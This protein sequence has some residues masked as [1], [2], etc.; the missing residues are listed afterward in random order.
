MLKAFRYLKPYWLSVLAIVAL[1]FGQVQA[2]LAL[3]DYMSD[4]VT[5]GIQY[6]GVT[7]S[8][9]AAMRAD[10]LAHM[11]FFSDDAADDYTIV[12]QGDASWEQEYPVVKDQDI[13]VKKDGAT[14]SDESK[15]AFLLVNM[16]DN[17]EVLKHMNLSSS[18]ELYTAMN[19]DPAIKKQI[20]SM[21]DEKLSGFTE[22]NIESAA[23]MAVKSEYTALCMDMEHLQSSYIMKEGGRMLL[24]AA[25]G[26]LA[27]MIAAY[28]ASRTATGAC[29]DMRRDVFAKVESFSNEEFSHFSTASL[30][31][32]TTNDIQQVQ[33]VITML[34]R[35]VLFAPLMGLTALLKVL[36]YPSMFSIL[37]WVIAVIVVLMLV[38]FT[39][40]MPRFKKIQKLVDRLNLV[41][42]E[43]LEGM[44]VIRAFNNQ[45]AEEKRFDDVNTDITKVNIFVNRLMAVMMPAMTFLMSFVSVLIIWFGARQIDAGTMQIGSMMAFLQYAMHVL[46]SFMI[47]AMIFIMLPR[48]SVSARRIFEVLETRPTILD[49]E[50]PKTMPREAEPITFDHVS[51]RYP[52]A[53]KD[54]LEDISFTAKPGQ[55]VAFIGSTGSGKSTLI[56]LIPRFFDVSK[57]AIYYGD[58]DIRDVTQHD[59]REK[60]GYVPQQGVLFSGTI[61]SNLKYA[62]ENASDEAIRNALEV[63]QAKEFVSRMPD[64]VQSAI[65][66]GGTNVSGGQKQ[67]LSIAR[68]LTRTK[69]Q[70]LIF[71]DTFSALDYATDARL[72]T[73]LTKMVQKTKAT[74]FIVA[75]RIS[76]IRHAD[77]I[78]VL[79][80]GR[81]A[82]IGTHEQLMQSCKVYQEIARSQLSQ[83]ELAR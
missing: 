1:I 80:E 12:K 53:E 16:L 51:F 35:I 43:Q 42:R 52:G 55:T 72:R 48:S 64:G 77:Q 22:D 40:A 36:R 7:S 26:S 14:L 8:E 54:V 76:T 27:A 3:P 11:A 79:D 74:V 21:A 63:S 57:G 50:H 70:I 45:K 9:P 78:V 28:L 65:A 44:L 67:R 56:N 2:E 47:V 5:Y 19:V 39:L 81:V 59:L 17:E 29:R 18:D 60:I 20:M 23:I 38:S 33:Q 66:Q 75:Q 15:K 34:L 13:A 24:I 25:L 71:D 30:I 69:A 37:L 58:T 73:A 10:T 83:E 32:R 49:P 68:A 62:D 82:G 6:G 31:T 41:T 46:I 4:I 61:A